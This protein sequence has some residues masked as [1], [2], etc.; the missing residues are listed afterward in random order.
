MRN[1][2]SAWF[3]IVFLFFGCAKKNGSDKSCLSSLEA[4]ELASGSGC[5]LSAI[6]EVISDPE[7]SPQPE[8]PSFGLPNEAYTFDADLNYINTTVVEEEKF[9]KAVELIKKIVA[10]EEFRAK[11]L[12]HTYNGVKTFVDNGGLSNA[13]VY[14]KVLDA[15][16]TLK[17]IKNNK[18]EMEVELYYAA[19]N[20][21]G[22]TYPNTSRIWVNTKYFNTYAIPSVA[23]NLMHEWLHKLGFKHAVAY[24][25]SRNYSVP[26]AIGSIIRSLGQRID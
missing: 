21:V 25:I 7:T 1:R 11:I 3:L 18:M 16:E 2:K 13:Q 20:T 26:Y 24:S 14:Q 5:S 15:A 8:N 10:T 22:Y 9:N 12:N 4:E 6:P 23:A 19:T 17:P